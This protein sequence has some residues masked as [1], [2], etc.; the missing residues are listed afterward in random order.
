[1]SFL[2]FITR[3]LLGEALVILLSVIKWTICRRRIAELGSSI[4]HQ[5]R[6]EVLFRCYPTLF[7]AAAVGLADTSKP[8]PTGGDSMTT[9][10][11]L[12]KIHPFEN[13]SQ[14]GDSVAAWFVV[15]SC[16]CCH[17][18]RGLKLIGRVKDRCGESP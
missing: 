17:K 14:R 5:L 1:M 15:F 12:R 3:A 8:I 6:I 11:P 2:V 4:E 16:C 13:F 9:L 10:K 7:T 18:F